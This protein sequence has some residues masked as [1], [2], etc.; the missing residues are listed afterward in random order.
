MHLKKLFKY[1]TIMAAL[2]LLLVGCGGEKKE[3][4]KKELLKEPI[5]EAAK[6]EQKMSYNLGTDPKTI[7]P[8]LNTAVDGAN[9]AQ[10]AFEGLFVVDQNNK[11]VEA[12]AESVK[13]SSD[14][15]VYTFSLRKNGKWSDG[16]PVTAKDFAY[17]WK[18]GLTAETG[19][20]YSYLLYYIKNGENFFNGKA[21]VEDLGIKV[22]DDYTLEV[23][24]ETATPYFLSL[25][26][27]PA[28]APLRED[29]VAT[30]PEWTT[31]PETY[32]GNGPFKMKELNPKENFVFVKNDNYW[33]ASAVKLN[34]LTFKVIDDNKTSL[35]AFKNGEIDIIDSPPISE[36]ASLLGDGT[37]KVYPMLG[38]YFYVF[39][40]SD[41]LKKI[42]P[43]AYK[44]IQ[45]S[46]VRRA[47]TISIDRQMLVE[48]VT[49]GG[50]APATGFVPKGIV[51]TDG[52]EFAVNKYI[53]PT[54][55][56]EQAKKLLADAGYPDPSK[57]PKLTLTYNTSD[58]HGKVA[59]AI[60][61]MWKT[62]LGLNIELKN[63]EWAVF[64]A[65]RSSK[66]Y[67]IARHGWIA[68]Y[69]DPINFLDL[70]VTNGGNNATGYS[71]GEYDRNIKAAI[72]E[73]NPENRTKLLHQAEDTLM[74]DMPIVPLYFYT[75]IVAAN[76]KVKGWY[77]T[78][79]GGYF[80]KG[81]YVE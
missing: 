55:Q 35:S 8:Q 39:N 76:P 4:P 34:E 32:V 18:R 19:M 77:R 41:T 59:Q 81:A 65:T 54:A 26:T 53:E 36:I 30:N 2:S 78:S 12:A 69:N 43:T 25:T 63:E 61:D 47:L 79:L 33:D 14:G 44:F 7:D 16:K 72:A 38:T 21:K 73:N 51:G 9:V 11:P 49:K 5:K 74:K 13:V 40:V 10:N 46:R 17:S 66:N 80:F 58:S 45:D 50:Q 70:W 23:T 31:K 67:E 1:T 68:D 52:K 22:V 48:K 75:S 15:L 27:L 3:E 64:Q 28:Y 20:E 42:D 29:I 37:A 71:S 24:L 56:I 6:V 60:Q 57:L 62:N